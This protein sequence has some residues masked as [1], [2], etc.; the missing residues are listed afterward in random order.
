MKF[1]ATTSQRHE[2]WFNALSYLLLRTGADGQAND[3]YLT[4]EDIAEF[5]PSPNK[6]W[7]SGGASLRSWR[8]NKS[9]APPAPS[10]GAAGVSTSTRYSTQQ[11]ALPPSSTA[12]GK[13]PAATAGRVSNSQSFS[14]AKSRGHMSIGSRISEYWK[15]VSSSSRSRRGSVGSRNSV[16]ATSATSAE[17][18]RKVYD[19]RDRDGGWRM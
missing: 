14:S 15:P 6:R 11:P 5:N 18:V 4:A 2:T 13:Q 16:G 10:S 1:T 3:G 17:D 7:T 8:S 12:T 19:T 9:N